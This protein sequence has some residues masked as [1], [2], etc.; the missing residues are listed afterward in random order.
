MEQQQTHSNDSQLSDPF[1]PNWC[2]R[3]LRFLLRSFF[4]V[5]LRYRVHGIDNIVAN[6]GGLFLVNHQSFLDPMIAQAELKR[7]VSWLARDSLFRIPVIGWVLRKTY[8]M[9]INRESAGSSSIR[10][11]LKRMECGFLVGIFPEGTRSSDGTIGPFKPG[12]LAILRRAQVPI[13]PVGIAGANRAMPRGKW[14]IRPRR[15]CVVIGT[16]FTPE[17]IEQ[18]IATKDTEMVINEVKKRVTEHFQQAE[19][20]CANKQILEVSNVE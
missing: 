16:P 12:F 3:T 17:E 13:Y 20:L 7:P 6:S 11:A 1:R 14:F 19:Q 5:W 4:L 9:P 2:W 18:F 15:V 8:T 10:T